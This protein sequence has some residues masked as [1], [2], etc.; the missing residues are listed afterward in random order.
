MVKVCSSSL[1]LN[2]VPWRNIY[3]WSPQHQILLWWSCQLCACSPSYVP[4]HIPYTQAPPGG[5]DRRGLPLH[6]DRCGHGRCCGWEIWGAL[7]GNRYTSD[8]ICHFTVL[9]YGN[10][11]RSIKVCPLKNKHPKKIQ[12]LKIILNNSRINILTQFYLLFKILKVLWSDASDLLLDRQRNSPKGDC[13]SERHEHDRRAHSWR[14][15]SF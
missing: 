10:S 15:G 1:W 8:Q 6:H 7:S 11:C 5:A 14:G 3:S 12:M 4:S 2:P 13:T 9:V